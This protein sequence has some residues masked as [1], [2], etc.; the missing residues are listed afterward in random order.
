MDTYTQVPGSYTLVTAGTTNINSGFVVAADGPYTMGTT[1]I[2]WAN[3][4]HR[5][6]VRP[7]C[8]RHGFLHVDQAGR[9]AVR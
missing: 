4:R 9:R 7:V 3:F 6:A 1:A 8:Y 2:N 5:R